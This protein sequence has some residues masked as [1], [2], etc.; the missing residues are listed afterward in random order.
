MNALTQALKTAAKKHGAPIV[1][2]V[3]RPTGK[4]FPA[5]IFGDEDTYFMLASDN[6]T[7]YELNKH[8]SK[9]MPHSW[10]DLG[11][12]TGMLDAMATIVNTRNTLRRYE[13]KFHTAA[14]WAGALANARTL[15]VTDA[16]DALYADYNAATMDNRALMGGAI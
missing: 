11:T 9:V 8:D 10:Q 13:R 1:G 3:T 4:A 6:Y 5:L 14:R 16:M 2:S 12:R 15:S 7:I